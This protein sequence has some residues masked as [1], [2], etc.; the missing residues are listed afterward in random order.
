MPQ[1]SEVHYQLCSSWVTLR[2]P[3]SVQVLLLV[4]ITGCERLPGLAHHQTARCSVNELQ[5]PGSR[6]SH[7]LGSEPTGVL[8]SPAVGDS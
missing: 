4:Q 5:T 8:E 1:N 2:M 7:H 3:P 6:Q